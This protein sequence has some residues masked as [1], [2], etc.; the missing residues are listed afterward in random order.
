MD[1]LQAAFLRVKLPYLDGWNARRREI[2]ERYLRE[3]DCTA[4]DL[5]G[6]PEWAEPSWHLF[7]IRHPE[8]DAL[9]EK[10]YERGIETMIHYPGD[11]EVLS[12]PCAPHLTDEQVGYVIEAV[13]VCA[14]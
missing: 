8:R 6:V 13:N 7:V 12:L 4:V 9:K 11:G 2:A 5:P 3:L 10:L 1:P 14:S